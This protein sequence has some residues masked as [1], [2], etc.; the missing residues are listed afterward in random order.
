M[1]SR[2]QRKRKQGTRQTQ[3]KQHGGKEKANPLTDVIKKTLDENILTINISNAY[4]HLPKPMKKNPVVIVACL[5]RID[6]K[7]LEMKKHLST[8]TPDK[9]LEQRRE[10][11]ISLY[12]NIPKPVKLEDDI[13]H[14]FIKYEPHVMV[15]SSFPKVLLRNKITL[16]TALERDPNVFYKLPKVYQR[17]ILNEYPNIL[18]ESRNRLNINLKG[19]IRFDPSYFGLV[20][21]VDAYSLGSSMI[22]SIIASGLI[23][24]I[25][26]KFIPTIAI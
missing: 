26:A 18:L 3:K 17:K 23:G 1:Y 11:I 12:R 20:R 15:D 10:E 7:Y 19:N 13:N 8:E 16:E 21:R 2:K 5:K 25:G 4:T 14:L 6:E 24:P 22:A 9:I